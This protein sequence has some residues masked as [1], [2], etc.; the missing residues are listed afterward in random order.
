MELF[1]SQVRTFR[2]F[3]VEPHVLIAK[4]LCR[5]F[6]SDASICVTG[7]SS[8]ADELAL[9]QAMPDVVLVDSDTDLSAIDKVIAGC[10]RAVPNAHICVLSGNLAPDVMTRILN[11][12]AD[13]YVVKDVTPDQLISCIKRVAT[14]GF[15]ADERLSS[16]VLQRS[17]RGTLAALT[18]R[19]FEVA[20]L[21]AQGLSNQ[22]IGD[23]LS[24]S[25]NTV[26]NHVANIF[27]KLNLTA[28]TQLAI[29]A[30]RHGW[31]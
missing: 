29:Y 24:L 9:A 19:E 25:S 1:P 11:A 26:K 18:Q 27:S 31:V 14:E 7:E 12:G 23:R 17:V 30:I 4:A 6:A 15:Y 8:S 2:V 28:R 16:W 20:K 13:G 21:I 5:S 22:D 10:R 3:L